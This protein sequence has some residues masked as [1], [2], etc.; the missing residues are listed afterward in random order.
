MKI[1]YDKLAVIILQYNKAFLTE[2]LLRSIYRF[3][4]AGNFHIV[5]VDNNSTEDDSFRQ[6]KKQFPEV[7]FKKNNENLGFARGINKEVKELSAS[8][9]Y[10]LLINNDITLHD[11]SISQCLMQM[12][13]LH[14]D[15]VTCRMFHDDGLELNNFSSGLSVSSFV[16]FNL[17][18]LSALWRKWLRSQKKPSRV[19]SITGAFLMLR[20]RVFIEVGMFTEDYFMYS[21]DKDLMFKLN[22][23]G[24]RMFYYPST[25]LVHSEGQSAAMIWEDQSKVDLIVKQDIEVYSKYTCP[26][27]IRIYIRA[28]YIQQYLKYIFLNNE[29]A[30]LYKNALA[31]EKHRNRKV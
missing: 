31:K 30:C 29:I 9:E 19:Y 24:A 25:C 6:F 26:F 16:F 4:N 28:W 5:V 20:K 7:I 3:E 10:I 1:S 8:I 13:I 15:A 2:S 11:N 22:N 27:A 18:G 14:A 23:V 17:T 12:N 21:E